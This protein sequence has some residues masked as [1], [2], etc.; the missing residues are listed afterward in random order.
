[1]NISMKNDTKINT[2]VS[3]AECRR[4]RVLA[5]T[6]QTPSAKSL[7]GAK[8]AQYPL[9]G[10]SSIL[11]GAS[12]ALIMWEAYSSELNPFASGRVMCVIY[13]HGPNVSSSK[14]D[15]QINTHEW[16]LLS[17]EEASYPGVLRNGTKCACIEFARLVMSLLLSFTSHP[18]YP[19]F[20]KQIKSPRT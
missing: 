3:S 20:P 8:P 13:P 6:L 17:L 11:T 9:A 14:H 16:R 18:R 2:P 19:K 12:C 10:E 4:A 1:M 15:K 5:H 7:V